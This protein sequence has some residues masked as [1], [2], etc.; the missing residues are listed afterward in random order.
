MEADICAEQSFLEQLFAKF[1]LLSVSADRL[2]LGRAFLSPSIGADCLVDSLGSAH[3][4]SLEIE[5]VAEDDHFQL[6][7]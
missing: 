3:I 4:A 6:T 1:V 7:V 5:Y 2:R